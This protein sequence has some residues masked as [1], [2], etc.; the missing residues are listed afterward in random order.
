MYVDFTKD[1]IYF[2]QINRDKGFTLSAM[3]RDMPE[4][5]LSK[6]RYL[7]MSQEVWNFK[8]FCNG[9]VLMDFRSLESMLSHFFELQSLPLCANVSGGS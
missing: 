6:I 8:P 2:G 9:H 7:G 3:I 1:I 5:E 4:R